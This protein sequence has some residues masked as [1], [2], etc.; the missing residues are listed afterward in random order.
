M[1]DQ[2]TKASPDFAQ[3]ARALLEQ[4]VDL[5]L[6][7]DSLPV[8]V[9]VARNIGTRQILFVNAEFTRL[10]GY[11][12]ADVPTIDHWGERAYPDPQERAR[13]RAAWAQR[14]AEAAQNGSVLRPFEDVI[15]TRDGRR[16]RVLISATLTEDMAIASFTEVNDLETELRHA[17]EKLAATA[18]DLTENIPVGTY[19]MV[20]PPGETSA[21]FSFVSRRFLEMVGMTR[22]QVHSAPH[23]AFDC[24]HPEDRPA[25]VALNLE[26][27]AARKP[28]SAT[29]RVVVGNETRWVHAE[30]IPRTLADGTVV[31]EGTLIDVTEKV[32][33]TRALESA[34]KALRGANAELM[35]LAVRDPLTGIWNRRHMA[36]QIEAAV[37]RGR[38]TGRTATLMMVDVD[39]FKRIND[40]FGHQTGDFVL[41]ELVRVMADVLR[42]TDILGRWGGEEFLLILPAT[43]APAAQ[44]LAERLRAAIAAHPFGEVGQVTVSIGLAPHAPPEDSRSWIARADDSLYCAKATGRNAVA[45]SGQSRRR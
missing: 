22:E 2:T 31:W 3:A 29:T 8:A 34:N 35:R 32:L 27:F 18:Y 16:V 36:T 25:W 26:T 45:P 15:T 28:F 38:A 10:F 21:G 40:R 30:S 24:V 44:A 14:T 41:S 39:H 42:P 17:R 5:G 37:M 7:L 19:T 23:R 1:K 9:S 6:L 13:V 33:T 4:G 12:R 43:P 11:T 20:M